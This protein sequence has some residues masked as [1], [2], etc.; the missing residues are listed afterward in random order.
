MGKQKE[1]QVYV[2]TGEYT[3]IQF[4]ALLREQRQCHSWWGGEN[5]EEGP[6]GGLS[7]PGFWKQSHWKFKSEKQDV[8]Q[9]HYNQWGKGAVFK[10]RLLEHLPVNKEGKVH[11]LLNSTEIKYLKII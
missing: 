3:H 8:I 11:L 7:L 1:L 6:G 5:S 9:G 10:W 4:Q 2:Y